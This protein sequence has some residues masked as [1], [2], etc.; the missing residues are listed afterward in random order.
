VLKLIAEGFCGKRRT[1]VDRRAFGKALPKARAVHEQKLSEMLATE[2]VDP[3]RALEG[4]N[5]VSSRQE[6]KMTYQR[7][8]IL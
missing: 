7:Y 5:S 2:E 1:T 4:V 3:G 6:A 8:L